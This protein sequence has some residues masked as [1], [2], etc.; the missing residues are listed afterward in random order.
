MIHL[1]VAFQIYQCTTIR[2]P[3]ASACLTMGSLVKVP[4]TENYR[5]FSVTSSSLSPIPL[6]LS[7]H[8]PNGHLLD[9]SRCL[10]TERE[11]GGHK[12][13]PSTMSVARL[14]ACPLVETGVS[15]GREVLLESSRLT[16]RDAWMKFMWSGS[17]P[18]DR[19]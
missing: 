7:S 3:A 15:S 8:V 9:S 17:A 10:R 13:K 1:V 14:G 5:K 18:S 6:S 19:S 16:L 4:R 2:M 12:G 11:R